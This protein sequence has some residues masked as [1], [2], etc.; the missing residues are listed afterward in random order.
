MQH[1]RSRIVGVNIPTSERVATGVVGAAAILL[2]ARQRSIG[3]MIAAGVGT[4]L[5][6]RAIAGRCPL[7]RARAV[8]KGIHVR[9]VITIQATPAQVYT[10]WRDLANL[11]RF[12]THVKSV[13]PEDETISKWVVE[14]GGK[15]LEWRAEIVED[16]P[17]RRLRWKSLGGDISHEGEIDIREAT[18]DR[19]TE[20]EVKM[21]YFPPGGLLTASML[22]GVLRKIAN[23]DIGIELAR[24]RQLLETGEIAT[25][26]R[27]MTETETAAQGAFR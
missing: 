13:T 24:L 23:V 14:V 22:Y 8:R 15:R 11:P 10:M 2:G 26:A 6:V 12:M 1:V 7:Y 25:G 19:G 27:V 5:V 21:H 18:G 9:R 20:V 17:N 3:G 4:A 16:S